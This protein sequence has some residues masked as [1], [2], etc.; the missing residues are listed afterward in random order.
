M[1][2]DSFENRESAFF[3]GDVFDKCPNCGSTNLQ[4]SRSGLSAASFAT[5]TCL[6]CK[7][8]FKRRGGVEKFFDDKA[9]QAKQ[10]AL[11]QTGRNIAFL[12]RNPFALL[13]LFMWF[14]GLIIWAGI[15]PNPDPSIGAF[16]RFAG[17]AIGSVFA[18]LP[19]TLPAFLTLTWLRRRSHP[20][21]SWRTAFMAR[22][23][24]IIGIAIGFYVLTFWRFVS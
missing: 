12:F 14:F 20:D 5:V 24:W 4:E 6:A 11:R 3:G 7:R 23:P 13:L 2:Y 21:E 9:E 22:P 16:R 19:L 8:S 15:S 17:I 1:S 18:S 10:A